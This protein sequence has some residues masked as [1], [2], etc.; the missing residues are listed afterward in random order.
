MAID[1]GSMPEGI[2]DC[3]VKYCTFGAGNAGKYR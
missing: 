1:I 3:C 2:S